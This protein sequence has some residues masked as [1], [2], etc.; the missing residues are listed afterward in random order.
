[1]KLVKLTKSKSTPRAGNP[2]SLL[3]HPHLERLLVVLQTRVGAEL[4]YVAPEADAVLPHRGDLDFLAAG[5]AFGV[6]V[7]V[8]LCRAEEFIRLSNSIV[9]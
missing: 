2:K 4:L 3:I 5:R 9:I 8:L 1:M 6:L 7:L